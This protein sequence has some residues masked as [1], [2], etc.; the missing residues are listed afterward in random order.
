MA[1]DS[2]VSRLS[3]SGRDISCNLLTRA[4][5]IV[6]I[7]VW[8]D[9]LYKISET[10]SDG[11]NK[12]W[13]IIALE[14]LT[15]HM[16][17]WHTTETRVAY[18]NSINLACDKYNRHGLHQRVSLTVIRLF[19]FYCTKRIKASSTCTYAYATV[20]PKTGPLFYDDMVQLKCDQRKAFFIIAKRWC[21]RKRCFY[22]IAQL[23]DSNC[24][25]YDD[26]D[27]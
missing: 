16:D 10:G 15:S 26:D 4:R 18:D 21:G 8:N 14:Q 5:I 25:I 24:S 22:P 13:E 20:L 3:F 12:Q 17:R 2:F 27:R 9:H 19:P 6:W 7:S 11:I 1:L 23:I